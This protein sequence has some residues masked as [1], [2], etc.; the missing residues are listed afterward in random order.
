MGRLTS[1]YDA[2][3]TGTPLVGDTIGAYLAKVVARQPDAEALVSL[4]Q[5]VRLTYKEFAVEVE[6]VAR[7]LLAIGVEKGDRV[8]IWAPTCAEWT[9][10]QFASARVGAILVNI[11]PAYRPHELAY[12]LGQSGVRVLVTA[13]AFKTSDYLAMLA[14]VRPGLTRLERV[15]TIDGEA[16]N[17]RDDIVWSELVTAES[18]VDP[19]RLTARE[20]ELDPDDPINI[21]YTSGTT[22]SPK[23]ATLSHHNIL[24]NAMSVANIVRYTNVD[25]VCVPVPLYHCFGMGIGNLGCI[26]TGATIVYPAA[27]FEPEATL[28]AIADERCTSIYGVPTMFIAELDHPRFAEF[29]LTSLRTGMM[30]GAPCPVEV[31]KRVVHDMH[32]SEI[33]IIY[34][35]TETSPV[36]FITRPDDDI[37]RRVT[38]VGTVLPGVEAKV[39]DPATGRTVE[40]GAPGEVC[41]RGYVVM[42]GYWENPEAT[43]E[44]VDDAGWMH[45]GD[46]GVMDDA[47]YLN[48]VGRIKDMVIRGGE[49]LYP[50]EI[51]EVLFSH[52]S[53]ASA[54]VIGVP[55]ERMGE[56]LMAW[57]VLRE[58]ATTTEDELREFCRSQVA[59]FKVPRYIRFVKDFPMTVTG[60]VQ[61]FKMREM[62]IEELGLQKAASI[63]TA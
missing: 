42:R 28:R 25:R 56:E 62:A 17:G 2:G 3:G 10:L 24:N 60:K 40:A 15:I 35:M 22:G 52:P 50:R 38:T 12:A 63:K 20:T 31:M 16:A 29:D 11:N 57:V 27:S 45:T 47:G 1:A 61:K 18:G 44:A 30:G 4:H 6:R 51:E 32:A 46:V 8:G 43:R 5:G 53:V 39:I 59:H 58:G 26:S 7:G 34:G 36:S 23:G 14:E 19:E 9:L 55:D 48:I 13:R 37:E 21:Q 33:C 54:Q 41:T 49:N